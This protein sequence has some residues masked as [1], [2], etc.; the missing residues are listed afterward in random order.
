MKK[1]WLV[2][3]GFYLIVTGVSFVVFSSLQKEMAIVSPINQGEQDINDQKTPRFS[4]PTDQQC[5]INGE[6]F[7]K[8]QREIW[9]TKRPLLVMI[10]NHEDCRPQTGL[11]KADIVYEAVAEGG[12]T[13]FM[14]VFYCRAAEPADKKYDLGPVRSSRTYFLD[15]ASEYADYPLYVHVGGAG[16]CNDPTV[17]SKAKALCQI[18]N[19]GWKDK[20][21]WSD[22]D[23]FALSYKV[24]RREPDRT[25]KTVATEHTMYCDSDSLWNEAAKRGLAAKG[26]TGDLWNENFVSWK[27]K[28]DLEKD[29]TGSVNKIAFDFWKGYS[30]YSVVWNY[31]EETNLYLRENGGVSHL[32][33]GTNAQIRSKVVIIQFVQE[34]GPVDE[35]KHM[36]YKM[37]GSGKALIFQDGKVIE[38]KW[39]KDSRQDRTIFTDSRGKEVELNQG[40]V[41]I[42]ILPAGNKVEYEPV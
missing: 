15:I 37:I 6:M 22:L 20:D 18:E 10:E 4:G 9:E 24:C 42:E 30:A 19:Y 32:D 33:F 26:Q 25:G 1:K 14:G 36:L 5:P 41:W 31:E 7:T 8:G 3:L 23:Q 16:L 2:Y 34:T 28:K 39:T 29:K 38:G 27:F 13:R 21:H 12:I 17:A 40:Q 11:S 35:H